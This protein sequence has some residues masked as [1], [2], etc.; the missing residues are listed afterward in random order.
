MMPFNSLIYIGRIVIL[1]SL[2]PFYSKA[3]LEKISYYIG[4]EDLIAVATKG[5]YCR[6]EFYTAL[7]PQDWVLLQKSTVARLLKNFPTF[8]GIRSFITVFTH[9][10]LNSLVN[11]IIVYYCLI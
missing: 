11:Q 8:Y 1:T 7:T 2:N 5:T 10:V 6:L 4:I 3:H 9:N